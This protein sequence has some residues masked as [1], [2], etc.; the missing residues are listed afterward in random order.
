MSLSSSFLI[1]KEIATIRT[2]N[3]TEGKE[4]ET[5]QFTGMKETSLSF[6]VYRD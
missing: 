3:L 6:R 5:M 4:K 2:N 1:G